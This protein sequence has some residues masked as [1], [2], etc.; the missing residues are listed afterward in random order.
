MDN[1]QATSWFVG[2]L[3]GEGSFS[4]DRHN[5]CRIRISNTESDIIDKCSK[6][7][8]EKHIIN[9]VSSWQRNNRKREYELVI[10]GLECHKLF[11]LIPIQC[12]LE[13]YQQILGSSETTCETTEDV[14]WLLGILEA[15]GSFHIS[16]RWSRN[17]TVNYSPE[18]TVSNTNFKIIAKISKTLY[19]LGIG[20]YI[21][22]CKPMKYSEYK[23]ITICGYK[24]VRSALWK[25]P[26][27]WV[28]ARI[29]KKVSMHLEFSDSRLNQNKV[30][31]YTEKQHQIFDAL[32][33]MI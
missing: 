13:Q 14:Y 22:H 33:L 28:S 18:I 24:R 10:Y 12:R 9:N 2:I 11:P 16:R 21:R 23:V 15:E 31:P 7:L 30:D 1:Q 25:I 6:I 3:E 17:N 8:F 5:G 29:Q 4:K 26:N 32:R 19:S 20:F 27:E